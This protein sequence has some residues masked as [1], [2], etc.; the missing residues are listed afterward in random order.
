[1]EAKGVCNSRKLR[2]VHILQHLEQSKQVKQDYDLSKTAP[3]DMLPPASRYPP[4]APS[5]SA[6]NT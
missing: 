5:N 3:S 1:M 4:R 6:S 2:G